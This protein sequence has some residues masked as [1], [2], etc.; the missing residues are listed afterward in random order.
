[1]D[2]SCNLENPGTATKIT[3]DY[4]LSLHGDQLNRYIDDL[5]RNPPD[6]L[7]QL[8]AYLTKSGHNDLAEELPDRP[9][10]TSAGQLP[11]ATVH[12]DHIQFGGENDA[13]DL[14]IEG[15]ILVEQLKASPDPQEKVIK[16]ILDQLT[17]WHQHW[18]PEADVSASQE[19]DK[20]NGVK[21]YLIKNHDD[22]LASLIP[23][24]ETFYQDLDTKQKQHTEELIKSRS[25]HGLR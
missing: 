16:P 4:I 6:E 24:E 5:R 20:L 9:Q 2:A 12:R 19:W 22:R 14:G 11:D 3:G 8:K 10:T 13:A 15:Q 17:R 21:N 18:T 23:D 1:M 7:C 25:E